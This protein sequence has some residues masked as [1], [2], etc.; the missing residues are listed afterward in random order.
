MAK[1]TKLRKGDLVTVRWRDVNGAFDAAEI[2]IINIFKSNVPAV[3]NGQIWLPLETLRKMMQMP[4]EAT[5]LIVSNNIVNPP[6]AEHWKFKSQKY[7]LSEITEIIRSKSI[8]G[9]ILYVILL[10]LAML[11]I[12]DTQVLSIFKRQKEIGMH[13]ALGMTRGQVIR[14]F[15]VEGAMHGLLAAI[16]AAIYGIPLLYLQAKYGISMPEGTDDYGLAIAQ[17]IF[18]TYSI[19]LI[20]GTTLLVLIISTVV[21]YLPTR[22]IAKM[23]PRDAIKGKAL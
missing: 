19:G 16:V 4:D 14:L 7:L 22:K 9:S 17:K 21:S 2:R 6:A 18:P 8:G 15:T 11:A 13:M 5:I 3:D 20:I 10:F 12:F 23:K 1:S